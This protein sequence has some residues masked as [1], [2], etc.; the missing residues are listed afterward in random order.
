[1]IKSRRMKK[2]CSMH[3]RKLDYIQGFG[4]KPEDERYLRRPRCKWV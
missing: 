1:M 2:A 4:K 3:G